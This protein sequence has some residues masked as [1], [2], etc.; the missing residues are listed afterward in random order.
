M[1]HMENITQT[2]K[3]AKR[4]SLGECKLVTMRLPVNLIDRLSDESQARSVSKNQI[5]V[6]ALNAELSNNHG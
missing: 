2:I 4:G 5:V 3:R 6:S 1:S